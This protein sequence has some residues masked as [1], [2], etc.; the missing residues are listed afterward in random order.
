LFYLAWGS[1]SRHSYLF[2]LF[3]P[4]SGLPP[5]ALPYL[6]RFVEPLGGYVLSA[7]ERLL[8]YFG[9]LELYGI[10][11]FSS[12]PCPLPILPPV[13]RLLCQEV[14]EGLIGEEFRLLIELDRPLLS[15]PMSSFCP[16]CPKGCRLY[17]LQI[18]KQPFLTRPFFSMVSAAWSKLILRTSGHP[19]SESS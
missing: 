5:K 8:L 18:G 1:L 7:M 17:N 3:P 16:S 13:A 11:L 14:D 19:P 12:Y 9:Q 2:H 15:S 6:T 10:F 4:L